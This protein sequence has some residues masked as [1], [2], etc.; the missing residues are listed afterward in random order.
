M[1]AKDV[2]L[3]FVFL[4]LFVVVGW[5]VYLLAETRKRLGPDLKSQAVT[6][7]VNLLDKL[8]IGTGDRAVFSRATRRRR[9]LWRA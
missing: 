2:A 7:T 3:L 1:Q 5:G 8:W 4:S 6:R 9:N